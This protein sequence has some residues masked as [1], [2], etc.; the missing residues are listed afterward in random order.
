MAVRE[1]YRVVGHQYCKDSLRYYNKDEDDSDAPLMGAIYSDYKEYCEQHSIE[2][3]DRNDL[4]RALQVIFPKSQAVRRN[5]SFENM[6][7]WGGDEHVE[8]IVF[9]DPD[10]NLKG[11]S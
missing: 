8:G 5:W 10:K 1:H 11:D 6:Y 4:V 9:I 2:P 3:A 7:E